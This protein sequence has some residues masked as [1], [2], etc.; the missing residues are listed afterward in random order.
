MQR[1]IKSKSHQFLWSEL[2]RKLILLYSI[3]TLLIFNSIGIAEDTNLNISESPYSVENISEAQ[4]IKESASKSDGIALLGIWDQIIKEGILP[5]ED[6]R[7]DEVNIFLSPYEEVKK[8][9]I[10]GV[11]ISPVPLGWQP[12]FTETFEGAFPGSNWTIYGSPSWDDTSYDKYNGSWSGWCADTTQLPANGYVNNMNAWMV[13][14]PFSLSDA[15]NATVDFYYRNKSEANFDY[16]NWLASTDGTNFYGWQISGN[17]D[18]WHSQTFDLTI[19]P[20]LGNL[21]GQNQVWIA[22][23]FK[24]DSSITDKGAYI[25]DIIIQKSVNDVDFAAVDV[26]PA[27][28][29]DVFTPLTTVTE[30]QQIKI[31]YKYTYTGPVPS[32]TH[33]SR[34]QLDNNTPCDWTGILNSTGTW[35][36]SC[37]TITATAGSHQIRGWADVN[38]NIAESNESNNYRDENPSFSVGVT[39]DIYISPT[40]LNII[41]NLPLNQGIFSGSED[42]EI[43][44]EKENYHGNV[45]AKVIDEKILNEFNKGEPY[46]NI[47]VLLLGYQNYE[48]L[49][50]ADKAMQKVSVQSEIRAKQ[51]SVLNQLD[52]SHFQLKHL[53]DN[54]LGFSGRVTQAGLD[55]LVSLPEVA[56]IEEDKIAVALS[57]Q[58]IPLMNAS[59]VRSSYDGSGV[60]VAIVDTGIDYTHSKLGG[61]GFPN[62]KVIG[63][64]DFGDSDTNPMDCQ[65]HGTSVAG[66][67]AGT[68]SSGPGDYVGGVAHNSKL[69]ALKIVT[70]CSIYASFSTIAAAWDWAVSHKNDDPNNPILVI[71]TSFGGDMYT[72]ACDSLQVALA[73]AAN[74]AVANGITLF[75][76]SGNNGYTNAIN[77]PACVSNS[78]SVGAVYDANIGGWIFPDVP[79]TDSSTD[80]DQVTCYSNS[81]NFLDILAPSHFAYTTAVGG[82]Y[83]STAPGFGG[84][85]AASPYAAGAAAILQ[86]Y[87]KTTTGFYYTPTDVKS[88][89]VNSGDPI[90]DSKNGIT[91]PRVNLGNAIGGSSSGDTFTIY[92]QGSGTLTITNMQACASWMT[93]NPTSPPSFDIAPGG[94]QGVTVTVNWNNVPGTGDSCTIQVYSNDPDE[95][96]YPGGVTVSVTA[97]SFNYS[98]SNS[99]NITVT[100]GSSGSNTITATLTSGTTQSVSF[101]A[102]GLPSGTTASFNPGSCNPTCSSTLTISTSASTPAGTYTI[103]V[104]GTPLG[105]TMQFDLI[106]NPTAGVLSVTPSD[107]LSSSGTQGGPF[108][109][110]SKTYILQNT[111]GS[112]INWTAS[113]GQTW[114]SLSSTS[115]TLSAGSS[116]TVTVSIN[117]NA[118]SFTPGTYSDTVIFTNATNG[119]GNTTRPVNLTVNC[120]LTTYYRDADSDGYG[121]PLDSTQACTQPLGYVTNNLDCDDSNSNIKPGATEVC[122]G[123]DND[124]NSGTPD[125]SGESWYGAACDGPDTDLCNEGIYQCTNGN[126]TCSD[127]TGDNIEVC[128]GIDNNCDGQI[129]EG[130]VC[131]GV[132]CAGQTATIVGTAG[133]DTINGTAGNDVIAG[134]GGN[135]KIYG[136]GGNDIICGGDGT[137]TLYGGDGDDKL[138]G[139]KG[140]DT[141]NGGSGND[142]MDGGTGTDTISF[143]GATAG[144]TAN[145]STGTVT[146]QGNDIMVVNTIEK[147]TG[148]N[149]ND[150]LTGDNKANTLTGG[151]GS[152]TLNGLGGN[153]TLTGG[154]GDDILNGGDGNDSLNGGSGNDT[155]D[156]GAGTDTVTFAGATAG[157]TANLGTGNATGYGN[158][159]LVLGTIEKITGSGKNDVL[160]GDNGANTLSGGAGDDALDGGA[161]T[162][163]CNGGTHVVGDTATNCET[164]IN[165]P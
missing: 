22:F 17:Q 72:S 66:I 115:G 69:Y 3:F 88:R 48:G 70:G 21:S 71:N 164:I 146:G 20:S 126:Q 97:P 160:T 4:F 62:S 134:L 95:N 6:V 56:V 83:T 81:A 61:G 107:G 131:G 141:L 98:L 102:S 67:A 149:Y 60:S 151:G 162:D 135:D 145:L 52:S 86:S 57:S 44:I 80:A 125:G 155:M 55:Y 154:A 127:T 116:T 118:N 90:T 165:I 89:L 14:G 38:N 137:D 10:S 51:N 15:T 105:K 139:E 45:S 27:D 123:A 130:G 87:A 34:V 28:P 150:N 133:N 5:S 54:I 159:T 132:T 158:D 140:S 35:Y 1:L 147:I 85:S 94:S 26:Y 144:V 100:Q 49:V 79:C 157:V 136:L 92:N 41:Q 153:D 8:Q 93:L 128:D 59:T 7:P 152:D 36:L 121:N 119:H 143:A 24:S 33:A 138:Y 50:I 106:V 103:T 40:S 109:P 73:T 108:T 78:L 163:T 23:V 18:S 82:G 9:R 76:A 53:F 12:I 29:A 84:T 110:S 64:F 99:G 31:V 77:A 46:V 156:G 114:V 30:G 112:S 124:C 120:Q 75:S 129:D 74:N 2:R 42:S 142:T 148:S 11:E 63:G 122:D 91:K 65:G 25:D 111:G 37:P 104:T 58:G 16:F 19:V 161:G 47:I 101:S 32:A 96:P 39:P 13:Y 117:S 43:G 68:L 113:K